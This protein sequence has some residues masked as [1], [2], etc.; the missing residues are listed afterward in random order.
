MRLINCTIIFKGKFVGKSR[1]FAFQ[2]SKAVTIC[3]CEYTCF[4]EILGHS[5]FLQKFGKTLARNFAR[6]AKGCWSWSDVVS[7]A[8]VFAQI[9]NDLVRAFEINRWLVIFVW[10]QALVDNTKREVLSASVLALFL[11]TGNT[12]RTPNVHSR[13]LLL[14][15]SVLTTW[16]RK[17][18]V[19]F[20][21]MPTNLKPSKTI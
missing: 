9:T 7:F 18:P 14:L 5:S 20:E 21:T 13:K 8:E 4:E 6:H 11:C 3:F 12:H 2:C 15:P 17:L 1:I 16:A 19:H 10:N